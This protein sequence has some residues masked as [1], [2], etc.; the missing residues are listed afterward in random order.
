M[1]TL[2]EVLNVRRD[3]Q[4]A[5]DLIR[6]A[7]E[8]YARREAKDPDLVRGLELIR[9][10]ALADLGDAPRAE[11]AFE[12]EIARF[13]DSVRAYSSLAILYAL[14]GRGGEVGPTLKRMVDTNPNPFAYAEAV[15]TLRILNDPG[16]ASAL[17]RHAMAR[18]PG[19]PTLRELVAGG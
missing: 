3:H 18:F 14:T 5:L 2:A 10:K 19:D 11:A 16:S 12:R 9:G 7:E 13:P 1:I 15:K 17:L 8:A 4:G 6:E